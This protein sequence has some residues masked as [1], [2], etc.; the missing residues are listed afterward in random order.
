MT[1]GARPWALG[2]GATL[3]LAAAPQIGAQARIVTDP[4]R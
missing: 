4:K 1:L 3:L 2:V